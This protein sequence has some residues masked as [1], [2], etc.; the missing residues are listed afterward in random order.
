VLSGFTNTFEKIRQMVENFL[1][2]FAEKEKRRKL[3]ADQIIE[4]R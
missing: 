3:M 2:P 4:V 1:N